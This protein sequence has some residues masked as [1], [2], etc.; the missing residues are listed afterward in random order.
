MITDPTPVETL[1][2]ACSCTWAR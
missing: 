2:S 1:L